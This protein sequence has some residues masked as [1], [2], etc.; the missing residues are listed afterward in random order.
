MWP[1]IVEIS[2]K[3]TNKIKKCVII[4]TEGLGS[5]E[6]GQNTDMKIFL[7]AV[8]LSSYLIYNSVGSIDEKAIENL[9]L[10]INLAELLHKNQNQYD[11]QQLINSFPSFMW[12]VRDFSLRL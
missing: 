2:D 6:E 9:S 3:N 8:L 7:M 12:L 11:S 1:K 4:D 5:L 10:V